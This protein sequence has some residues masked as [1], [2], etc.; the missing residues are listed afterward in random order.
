MFR[1]AK[2]LLSKRSDQTV[3]QPSPETRDSETSNIP[4]QG[5][6]GAQL[7]HP[8]SHQP[9]RSPS[10]LHDVESVNPAPSPPAVHESPYGL[11]ELVSQPPERRDAVD[12]IAIHGLNGHPEKTWTDMTTKANWLCD[13][14]CLP[15]DVPNARILSF[16]Y[17]SASYFSRA[18]ADVQDFASEL[19]AAIKARRRSNAE[20]HR[21]IMFICHSLGGL[22]FKQ[23][24]VRAHEQDQ[25]YLTLLKNIQGVIFFA[26]PHKGS[27]LAFWDL[28]GNRIVQASTLGFTTNPK[29]S[30]DLKVDSKMLKRISD[31]FAYRGWSIK[32][33]S[34]YET[35]FMSGLNCRVVNKDSARLGWGNE[36]DIASPANHSSICKFAS[37]ADPRYQTAIDAVFDI[38][39][40]P[41]EISDPRES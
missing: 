40:V 6:D 38:I 23:A 1:H 3:K 30:K 21:P 13:I 25:F 16:G 28:I 27:S 17:N 26:T 31:S 32:I 12:I 8:A 11:K 22:V 24:I 15:K 5:H 7:I 18:D 34:F 35:E 19:L 14:D 9:T 37:A 2:R 41:D 39:G 4:A 36:L 10:T 33:R 29:L 20:K